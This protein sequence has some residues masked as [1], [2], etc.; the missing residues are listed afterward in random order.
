MELIMEFCHNKL[1]EA[2]YFYRQMERLQQEGNLLEFTYNLSAFLTATRSIT[3]YV[4]DIIK[5]KNVNSIVR[6]DGKIFFLK[7][8]RNLTV[9]ERS[10]RASALVN[11]NIASSITVASKEKVKLEMYQ[12]ENDIDKVIF[13]T[14]TEPEYSNIPVNHTNKEFENVKTSYQFFLEEWEGHDDIL[15]LAKYYLSWLE[16]FIKKYTLEPPK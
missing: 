11:A 6:T 3:T 12:K 15:S 5:D 16:E 4:R 8:Q 7:D 13:K 10:L 2:Y 1:N 14:G 9:H